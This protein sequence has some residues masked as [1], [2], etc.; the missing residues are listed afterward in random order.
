MFPG[1]FLI[2]HLSPVCNQIKTTGAATAYP[3]G[4][5]EFTHIFSRGSCYSILVLC[6]Y[7]LQIVVCPFVLVLLIILWSVLLRYTDFVLLFGI[8]KLFSKFKGQSLIEMTSC[9][10]RLCHCIVCHP[11]SVLSVIPPLYYLS[12]FHCIFCHPSICDFRIRFWYVHA[13]LKKTHS[14]D[15]LILNSDAHQHN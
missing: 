2:H 13:F 6:F 11:S 10:M 9:T 4:T 12:S 7:A 1:H 8:F 15:K 14:Y 5:P 3:S